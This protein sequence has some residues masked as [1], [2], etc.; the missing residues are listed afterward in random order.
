MYRCAPA[1]Q[2]WLPAPGVRLYVTGRVKSSG[3]SRIY[4]RRW[5]AKTNITGMEFHVWDH[6]APL[7]ATTSLLQPG[8]VQTSISN[9]A[10][11][12]RLQTPLPLQLSGLSL[13]IFS[14]NSYL[15][16]PPP[17]LFRF[18]MA[19]K[20]MWEVDPETRSK[21]ITAHLFPASVPSL[22][23]PFASSAPPPHGRTSTDSDSF[24][25]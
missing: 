16:S 24:N 8:P 13:R 1:L 11:E 21:V 18:A 4:R 19:S 12:P 15:L 9:H 14:S 17:L 10:P 2:C 23:P 7:A 5:A 22:A 3:C 25:R 6:P 20:A